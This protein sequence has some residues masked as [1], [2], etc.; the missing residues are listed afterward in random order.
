M[1]KRQFLKKY[2]VPHELNEYRPHLWRDAGLFLLF[3]ITVASFVAVLSGNIILL[4]SDLTALVLPKVLVDYTNE[5]RLVY[6]SNPLT[7]N[8][9]LE[10]AAQLKADDMASKGYFA[11]K[12]P[13]GR[14]PWYWFGQAG[15]DFS[16]AGENL[17]VNFSDSVDVSQAWM[18]SPGHRQNI[19]NGNFSEIGIATAQGMYQGRSTI[20]VVQLF[21][22]PTAKQASAI[23]AS[24]PT[25]SQT[26]QTTVPIASNQ[27]APASTETVLSET[28]STETLSE[29]GTPELFISVEKTSAPITETENVSQSNFIEKAITSPKELLSIIYLA[30]SVIIIIGLLFLIFVEIEHRNPRLILLGVGLLIVIGGLLYIYKSI[31]FAPLLIA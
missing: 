3:F 12:S 22:R 29:N 1:K 30:I 5:N 28:A 27:T 19:L 6:N 7:I 25:V 14:N 31:L 11:H 18:N 26:N 15:Y 20:F 16:Y 13:E 10:K 17:A 2:F 23:V 21:G 24:L 9:V 8:P 4:R